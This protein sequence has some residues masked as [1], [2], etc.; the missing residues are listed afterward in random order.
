MEADYRFQPERF[1][2][3][4][5]AI[6]ILAFFLRFW[7]IGD[8]PCGLFPD[9]ATNA[10]EALK[11]PLP[12]Y[13]LYSLR[14]GLFISLLSVWL[15]VFGFGQWQVIAL[16]ALIGSLTIPA[17]M[18]A[19]RQVHGNRVSLFGGLL[20]A[21]SP[22]H[23]AI[24]RSGFRVVLLPLFISLLSWAV[25]WWFKKPK[26][27]RSLILG[28]LFALGFYT[29]SAYQA[30]FLLMVGALIYCWINQRS[31]FSQISARLVI[32]AMTTI[33]VILPLL[34]YA[35]TYPDRFAG[36]SKEVSVF[37]DNLF[38][39]ALYKA[40]THLWLSLK[41]FFVKGDPSWISNF[42][43]EPFVQ[44]GFSV[45]L[46]IGLFLLAFLVMGLWSSSS[47]PAQL[48]SSLA[49]LYLSAF[50]VLTFPAIFTDW[51]QQP[52]GLRLA[53]EIPL[54]F[55]I[56]AIGLVWLVDALGLK[57]FT[58]LLLILSFL[59]L[60]NYA[61]WQFSRLEHDEFYAA[62]FRCDLADVAHFLGRNIKVRDQIRSG[63]KV[64]VVGSL[65]DRFSLDYALLGDELFSPW[66]K[67]WL[68]VGQD[69]QVLSRLE[70]FDWGNAANIVLEKDALVIV[71]VHGDHF[72]EYQ[73]VGSQAQEGESLRL[74]KEKNP[75]LTLISGYRSSRPW[76][77][78]EGISFWLYSLQGPT[79]MPGRALTR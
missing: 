62:A 1:K 56:T 64:Y 69:K 79:L 41:G 17:A 13:D 9:Q 26:V 7:R 49:A 52:H 3:Y 48:T 14:E 46:G 75:S 5:L 59:L 30:V 73:S 28:T 77:Y 40:S 58:P 66:D 50:F 11:G 6:T 32:P 35:L 60:G 27:L 21:T 44:P 8:L 42:A 65:F 25:V 45:F 16:S 2:L 4:F 63:S 22:W 76:Y 67:V 78:P 19:I 51:G 68:L 57:R 34:T 70:H 18:A 54:V 47:A 36:R 29:Y 43:K 72:F 20:L 71:P 37:N 15:R 33:L 38:P 10:L 39:R 24:S 53:G 74:L 23:I 61:V 55:T 12:F 31:L